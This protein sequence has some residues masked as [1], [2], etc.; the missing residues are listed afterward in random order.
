MRSVLVL[1]ELLESSLIEIHAKR[2]ASIWRAVTGLVIGGKLWLTALGRSLPGNTSDKHRIKAVN[3]L[4]GKE[5]VH[6]QLPMFYRAL[7]AQLLR[8]TKRP[9]VIVDWTGLASA[10]YILSAQLCCEGRSMPLY[11]RV[12]PKSS[13]GNPGVQSQ[14][15]RELAAILPEGSRPI[16]VTDAGF[17][18]PWFDAVALLGWD[19]VGR[20]RNRT[21]VFH[22]EAWVP[23]NCLH[24][25]A[26]SVARDLGWL[27][28][29][30]GNARLYRLVLSARPILKGRKRKTRRGRSGNNTLDVKASRGA[31]E[32][33]LLVTSLQCSAETVVSTYKQRM[34]IEQSFRDTKNFRHGWAMHHARSKSEKRLEILLLIAA[35][36][37]VALQ[38]IGRAATQCGAQRFFQANTIVNRR[39]LSF[40]VLGRYIVQSLI[41]LPASALS[42]ALDEIVS[43]IALRSWRFAE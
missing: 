13:Q 36:A 4:L 22:N 32:P 39:V 26:G 9:V 2:R 42:S 23:V 25:L 31:R 15:L 5:A 24:R 41:T 21:K 33:W 8:L 18:S 6:R 37:F 38:L 11:N 12:F 34:H 20:I 1:Q 27:W 17:R 10:H 29:P 43:T 35:L 3:R 16:V 7:G 14:F 28:L 19:Y 30:R 40:F